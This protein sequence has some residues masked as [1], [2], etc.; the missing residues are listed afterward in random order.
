[1]KITQFIRWGT[2]DNRITVCFIGD[3]E[4]QSGKTVGK[5]VSSIAEKENSPFHILKNVSIKETK[6]CNMLFI[7]RAWEPTL[8][9]ILSITDGRPIVTISDISSFTRRGGMFG[10]Y[11]KNGALAVELN[12]SK[13]KNNNININSVLHGMVSIVE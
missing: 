9:D 1:M 6:T 8:H 10:F 12:L 7:G 11:D 4:D 5:T 2:P 13:V 3:K